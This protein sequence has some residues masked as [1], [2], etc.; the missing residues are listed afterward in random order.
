MADE[1][2]P[3]E[4]CLRGFE[5]EARIRATGYLHPEATDSYDDALVNGSVEL[6]YASGDVN[7]HADADLTF[8]AADLASF[9]RELTLLH[10]SLSGRA[11]LADAHDMLE[12]R[13]SLTNGK[14]IIS[15]SLQ[16][17]GLARFEFGEVH[18]DQ[19]YLF[20]AVA[21]LERIVERFPPRA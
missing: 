11:V 21:G 1:F 6:T 16:E 17:H 20:D 2:E 9:Q 5:F 18:T 7:W 8:R 4:G 10:A 12:L 13:V 14:G 3:H 19:S 15:G